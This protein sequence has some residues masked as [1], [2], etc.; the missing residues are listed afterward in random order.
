MATERVGN[1]ERALC[2]PS[3]MH[4][5]VGDGTKS[6]GIRIGRVGCARRLVVLLCSRRSDVD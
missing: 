6:W 1:R 5:L 3:Q 4:V 2:Q